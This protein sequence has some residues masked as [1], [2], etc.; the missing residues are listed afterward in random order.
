MK[1]KLIKQYDETDCGPACLAMVSNYYG[2]RVAITKLRDLSKTDKLGTSLYGL[3]QAGKSLNLSMEAYE[4]ENL[5]ELHGF[6]H[7]IIAHIHT[8]KGLNH[9]IIIEK[10]V[11]DKIY[12]VDPDKG[13][14]V[15][16]YEEFLDIFTFVVIDVIPD[17]NFNKTNEVTPIKN[18]FTPIIKSNKTIIFKIFIISIF[19]NIVGILGAIY[20]QFLIDDIIPSNIISNLHK[21][22]LGVLFIY[23]LNAIITYLRYYLVLKLSLKIDMNLM[24]NYF[25]HV[26]KLPTRFFDTRKSGEI[27]S[28]F[29]DIHNIREA[30]SS[31]LVTFFVDILLVL[32]GSIIL[33]IKSKTLF[34][35]SCCFLPLYIL[36]PIF[37]KKPFELYNRKVM[38]ENADLSTFLIES[39]ENNNIIKS[40]NYEKKINVNATKKFNNLIKNVFKLGEYHNIQVVLNSFFNITISIVILWFGSYLVMIGE[41][42]LGA[43]IAFNAL[44][45]YFLEPIERIIGVQPVIQSSIVAAKRLGE[46]LDLETEKVSSKV[47]QPL[48]KSIRFEDVSFQYGY[49]DNTLTNINMNIKKGAKIAIVGESGS[50]KSTLVKLIIRLYSET[51]GNIYWD[52]ISLSDLPLN[53]LRDSIGYVPQNDFWFNGSIIENLSLN[54]KISIGEI[55]KA[56][57]ETGAH[58]FIMKLPNKYESILENGGENLSGGQ[59][60]KLSIARAII[61]NPDIYVLDEPTSSLDACS[62]KQILKLIEKLIIRNKTVVLISHKLKN[63]EDADCIYVLKNGEIIEEGS[64]NKLISY[65]TEYREL[66]K[67][68]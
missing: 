63:V 18:I 43:L 2:K 9:F 59:K 8:K 47:F 28:R 64:H 3:I 34:L 19:I 51:S 62:E 56:C 36:L 17:K 55:V 38:E 12:I 11:D 41:L 20:F 4:L 7:P 44:V 21:L 14:Y 40:Y 13:K 57:K 35:L 42:S 39:F 32:G 53:Y 23:I 10:I 15:L 16:K 58:E 48:Q 1:I 26:M 61:K 33:I 27:L 22:F 67:R 30:L 5:T 52:N 29:N 49:R 68:Q 25:S 50:G 60:Q 54:T 66:W 37:F 24:K 65:T 31:V 6:P 46:I 45:I